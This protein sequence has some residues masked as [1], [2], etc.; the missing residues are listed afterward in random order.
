MQEKNIRNMS[1]Q[2]NGMGL[3]E[4]FHI[5]H[6]PALGGSGIHVWVTPPA[7]S[8]ARRCLGAEARARRRISEKILLM[9]LG[10]Y[11][12]RTIR[13]ADLS[14]GPQGKPKLAGGPEF[15]MSHSAGSSAV[16]VSA[17]AVGIDIEHPDRIVNARGLASRYFQKDEALVVER[18]LD[19]RRAFLE[20]WVRKEAIAKLTGEGIYRG[21]RHTHV[22]R[23]NGILE[24][25]CHDRTVHFFP[26]G[27][28]VGMVGV[29]AS[30]KKVPVKVFVIGEKSATM[31]ACHS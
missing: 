7:G 6:I 14:H 16:A 27:A 30:W 12:G 17:D 11:C 4:E 8:G 5:S 2:N 29:V 19:P 25:Q 22:L 20:F 21:M 1:F 3:A 15:N 9:L 26:F 28:E 13:T 31:R 10:G 18:S 24:G 23:R